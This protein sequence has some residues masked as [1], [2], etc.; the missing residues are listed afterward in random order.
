MY[1]VETLFG[2]GLAI[3]V[4][5]GLIIIT[6]YALFS[7]A[8]MKALQE[9]GYDK[10]WLAWIPYGVWYAC[11]DAVAGDEDPVRLFDSFEVPGLVFKL[12]WIVPVAFSFTVTAKPTAT[13]SPAFTSTFHTILFFN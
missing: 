6:C 11:A 2:M 8:H 3:T 5:M 1:Y 7:I 4:I 9:M 10:P 12:W 13:T